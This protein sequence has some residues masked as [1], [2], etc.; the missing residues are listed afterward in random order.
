MKLTLLSTGKLKRGAV[1]ELCAE[2]EKRLGAYATLTQIELPQVKDGNPATIKAKEAQ[3]QLAK[4]P[5]GALLI[6]LDERGKTYST[7]Q[8]AE[9]LNSWQQLAK[10]V[11]FL[12][13]GAEGLDDSV[14]ARA[15]SVWSLSPLTFPHQLVRA[16][17]LEQLYRAF[18]LNAGH[19]YHR[20]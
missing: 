19:P 7:A 11:I 5:T 14:R 2:Y 10:P 12:I 3:A 8:F 16:L 20:E 13:G 4:V 9:K 15:D 18:S 6:A 1:S 17:V